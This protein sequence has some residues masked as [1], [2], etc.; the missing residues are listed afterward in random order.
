MSKS[1]IPNIWW[2][3]IKSNKRM[4]ENSFTYLE[5]IFNVTTMHKT[6]SNKYIAFSDDHFICFFLFKKTYSQDMLALNQGSYIKDKS[7][8]LSGFLLWLLLEKLL[9]SIIYFSTQKNR[10]FYSCLK[11]KQAP[12]NLSCYNISKS[13]LANHL[14]TYIW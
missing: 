1:T 9:I 14:D 3:N 2:F 13:K 8:N 12:Q 10:S 11:S 5:S 7:Q 4:K 6:F